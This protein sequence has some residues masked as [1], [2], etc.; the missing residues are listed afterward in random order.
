MRKII[1]M[2]R[3]VFD[4]HIKE[5]PLEHSIHKTSHLITELFFG[6]GHPLRE[7]LREKVFDEDIDAKRIKLDIG[8]YAKYTKHPQTGK[9]LVLFNV[10]EICLWVTMK[11]HREQADLRNEMQ[12]MYIQSKLN[13]YMK[14]QGFNVPCKNPDRAFSKLPFIGHSLHLGLL[15]GDRVVGNVGCER[16]I[17]L[18]HR[19]GAFLV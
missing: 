6:N 5:L 19:Y 17:K 1:R 9:R 10:T 15:Q 2:K 12:T 16:L 18:H 3:C 7:K 11:E 13:E 14:E 4:S 8:G